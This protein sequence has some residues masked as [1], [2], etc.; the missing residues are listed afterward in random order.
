MLGICDKC[1]LSCGC[2]YKGFI[3]VTYCDNFKPKGKEND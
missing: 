3:E 2:K 1:A